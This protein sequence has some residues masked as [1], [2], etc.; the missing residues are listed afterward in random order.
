MHL[1]AIAG[2]RLQLVSAIREV[3]KLSAD[4]IEKQ[5]RNFEDRHKDYRPE[6]SS[7]SKWRRVLVSA[8]PRL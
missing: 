3:Y 8:A 4:E 7:C 5:I 6:N 1:D 2:D